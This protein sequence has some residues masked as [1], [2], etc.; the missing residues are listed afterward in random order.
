M[1]VQR[2]QPVCMR[3]IPARTIDAE[4]KRIIERLIE[5]GITPTYNKSAD[6]ELLRRA[7]MEKFKQTKIVS[8]SYLTISVEE[9]KRILKADKKDDEDF[10]QY[11]QAEDEKQGAKLLGEQIF[12]KIKMDQAQE[13]DKLKRTKKKNDFIE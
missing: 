1:S 4:H 8:E 12:L 10:E 11:A 5:L 2:I 13:L 9:Q 3:I 6:K 7:E